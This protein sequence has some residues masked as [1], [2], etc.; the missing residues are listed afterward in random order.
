MYLKGE[1]DEALKVFDRIE[2]EVRDSDDIYIYSF[3]LFIGA[4]LRDDKPSG[5]YC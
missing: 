4:V 5:D 1:K 2:D 3:A